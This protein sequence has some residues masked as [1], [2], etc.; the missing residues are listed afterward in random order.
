VSKSE[1]LNICGLVEHLQHVD[2]RKENFADLTLD[3][4]SNLE[5]TSIGRSAPAEEVLKLS[6]VT[7][8]AVNF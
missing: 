3:I 4:N 1:R 6:V 5:T 2:C 8:N 7:V